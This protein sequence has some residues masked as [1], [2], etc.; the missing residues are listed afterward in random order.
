MVCPMHRSFG[1]VAA[2]TLALFFT[3]AALLIYQLRAGEDPALG[4]QVAQTATPERQRVLLRKV[5]VT[6]VVH[7]VGPAAV[8]RSSAPVTSAP[9]PAAAPAPAPAPAPLTTQSS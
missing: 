5:I 3:V 7:H 9:A 6:R 8:P 1:T 4:D 2:A